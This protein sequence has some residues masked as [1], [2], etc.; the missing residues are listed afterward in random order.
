MLSGIQQ[1]QFNASTAYDS[2]IFCIQEMTSLSLSG[3]R[4]GMRLARRRPT[5]QVRKGNTTMNWQ[6]QYRVLS[7]TGS[8]S[9]NGYQLGACVSYTS[10]IR[11]STT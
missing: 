10:S 4:E 9:I 3:R 2:T 5:V 6:W 1:R 11:N 7:I 8:G